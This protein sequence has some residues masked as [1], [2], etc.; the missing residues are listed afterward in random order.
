MEEL[1]KGRTYKKVEHTKEK[2]P[3]LTFREKGIFFGSDRVQDGT[4][5]KYSKP[6]KLV[7]GASE[8]LASSVY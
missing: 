8:F 4:R 1:T 5:S 6:S 3:N 2:T 7:P